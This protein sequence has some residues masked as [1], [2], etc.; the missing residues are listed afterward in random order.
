VKGG[1]R[2]LVSD[3]A[4]AFSDRGHNVETVLIPFWSDPAVMIEQMLALRLLELSE[5]A[6]LL[7]A[8]RTPSYLLRHPNKVV[9]FLHHHRPA[10]DL[11]GTEY[12]ESE[13]LENEAVRKAILVADD[14][15]LR[16]ARRLY[17]VSRVAAERLRRFNDLDADVLYP[18]LGNA[19]GYRC[20]NFD[21]YVFF[22]SRITPLKRQWLAVEAMAHV[23]SRVRLVI[24]GSP[25]VPEHMD[26]LLETIETHAL[27]DRV[28]LLGWVDDSRKRE[29]YANALAVLFT[30]QDEDFGYVGL[31]SFHSG[32]PII[33]CADSGGVLELVEDEISGHVV[34]P[35][36]EKLAEAVDELAAD[37]G[38]AE[39]LG[40]RGHERIG[41]LGISWDTVVESL[42]R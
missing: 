13:T 35:E 4:R 21:D 20:E 27:Q 18:P 2:T 30:P 17:A 29:L 22:P 11:R 33:T 16:E 24:A 12:D 8:I 23:R 34:P 7:V 36:P 14:T 26:R 28:E 15:H 25:D 42:S 5:D 1:A 40:S 19:A 38:R 9:W 3:L 41:E 32:K 6:D 31:E 37:R 10:Y 39:Q